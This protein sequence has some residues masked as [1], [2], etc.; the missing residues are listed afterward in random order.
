[1]SDDGIPQ[2][3]VEHVHFDAAGRLHVV[4]WVTVDGRRFHANL[5]GEGSD[6]LAEEF[7]EDP[8]QC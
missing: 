3:E 6:I 5:V 8:G 4:G 2:L 7:V 1:M